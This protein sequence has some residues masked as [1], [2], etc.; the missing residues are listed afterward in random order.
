[1]LI[2][3]W[4]SSVLS[5]CWIQ[6]CPDFSMLRRDANGSSLFLDMAAAASARRQSDSLAPPPDA[7]RM[8]RDGSWW[9]LLLE[10]DAVLG[11]R[12]PTIDCDD[13]PVNSIQDSDYGHTDLSEYVGIKAFVQHPSREHIKGNEPSKPLI[14]SDNQAPSVGVLSINWR[15]VRH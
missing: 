8:D 3:P 5:C 4:F 9:R 1:M 6:I 15:S 13:C 7:W 10:Q 12:P 2:V 14:L 11:S